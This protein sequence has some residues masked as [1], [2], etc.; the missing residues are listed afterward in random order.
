MPSAD[1]PDERSVFVK[2]VD[3]SATAEDLKDHF[4]DC[5]EIKR[6]TILTDKFTQKPKGYVFISFIDHP[7][8]FR[9]AYVE[10][11]TKEAAIKAKIHNESLFKGR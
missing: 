1:D 11:S 4:S 10:F 5:G 7:P 9:Y 8:L 2:N 3:F 6:I